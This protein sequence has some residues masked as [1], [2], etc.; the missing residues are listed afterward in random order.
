ML[1]M[2]K[3]RV[4]KAVPYP[5]CPG[6]FIDETINLYQLTRI[7]PCTF[8][9]MAYYELYLSSGC[10]VLVLKEDLEKAFHELE[11]NAP[12]RIGISP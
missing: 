6:E 4:C 9:G 10:C 5:D 3:I 7:S 8:V 2:I 1:L 11:S 12:Q